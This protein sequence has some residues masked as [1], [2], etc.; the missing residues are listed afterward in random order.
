MKHNTYNGL[1]LFAGLLT[2]A[3]IVAHQ[4]VPEKRI[5]V[6]PN[7]NYPHAIYGSMDAAGIS[8]AQ[9]IDEHTQHWKCIFLPHHDY[10]CGYSLSFAPDNVSGF[11]LDKY[12]GL[13]I[14]VNY[15]GDAQRIRVYM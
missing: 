1:R 2:I 4:H 13:N 6:S 9:W 10:S 15:K 7:S 8:S 11:D 14:K 12:D 3:I 5:T